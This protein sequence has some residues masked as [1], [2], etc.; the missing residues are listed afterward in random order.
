MTTVN[1]LTKRSLEGCRRLVAAFC[2]CALLVGCGASSAKPAPLPVLGESGESKSAVMLRFMLT[3]GDKWREVT[4][5]TRIAHF[6]AMAANQPAQLALALYAEAWKV[7][8]PTE[9][10]DPTLF[11]GI[12]P[13]GNFARTGFTII[14]SSGAT[15]P[16]S[17]RI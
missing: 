13:G 15:V 14:E 6:Q 8:P 3:E 1:T 10:A 4:D 16:P 2:W 12:Q 17:L 9:F 5:P 7:A 11:I